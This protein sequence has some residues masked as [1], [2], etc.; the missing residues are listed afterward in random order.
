LNTYYIVRAEYK[1]PQQTCFSSNLSQY[2]PYFLS[3]AK[4]S[5]TTTMP[6]RQ[7]N[8]HPANNQRPQKRLSQ[9]SSPAPVQQYDAEA[10]AFTPT[11]SPTLQRRIAAA[12]LPSLTPAGD[13]V[14]TRADNIA[15]RVAS[16]ALT[17]SIIVESHDRPTCFRISGIPSDWSITHLEQKLQ[18]IDP[19]LDFTDVDLSGPF[20]AGCDST[21]IALLDF[22]NCTAYFQKLGRNDEKLI[23]IRDDTP[24]RKVRLTID[25]HF[26]DMTPLNKPVAPITAE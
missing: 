19:K 7:G 5:L 25:K 17:P 21:Q 13:N 20:P 15:Q 10:A 22:D 12:T 26:Y 16:T 11:D 8:N 9:S 14:P 2:Y 24:D 18:V 6:K 4:S 3:S 23:V 1:E